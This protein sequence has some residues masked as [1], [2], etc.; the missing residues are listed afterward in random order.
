MMEAAAERAERRAS[1]GLPLVGVKVVDFGWALAGAFVGKHLADYGAQVVR[2]E[3]RTRIDPVRKNQLVSKSSRS[4]VDDKPVFT[5]Y[6]TSKYSLALNLKHPLAKSVIERLVCWADV[7]N[8]NFTPGTMTKLGLDYTCLK[9][10]KPDIIMLGTSVY[11]QTGPLAQEWGVD[12]TGAGA[13]G[14]RYLTGWPDRDPVDSGSPWGDI[15]LPLVGA[16]AVV[17][18][19]DYRRRTGKG[20]Y[21]DT[22]M[23]GVCTHVITPALLDWQANRHLQSRE[24]N[25]NAAA[26]PHG[27]FPCRGDERWC[28][29]SVSSEAEW[30]AFCRVLGDPDRANDPRFA[31]QELRKQNEDALEQLIAEWTRQYPAEQVME[32][33]QA[34]GVPAGLVET[35]EDLEHDPQLQAREWLVSMEHPAMGRLNH[36]VPAW[37]LS[38]TTA[39]VRRSPCIGEH[40]EHVCTQLL[41]MSADEFARMRDQQVFY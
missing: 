9:Q 40:D 17:A 36:P 27:V 3:S 2:V 32:M 39:Q 23:I 15:V 6:N 13:S 12:G 16:L 20:Q 24:G 8:E 30:Q 31:T 11:G 5:H 1:S 38:K 35:A 33:M 7:V 26:A 4:S 25:R 21:I 28:A 37:K 34:A 41:G 18:A 14:Y 10:I 29:I 19:L 22:S